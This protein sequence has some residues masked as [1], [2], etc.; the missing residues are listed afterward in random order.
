MC[1]CVCVRACVGVRACLCVWVCGCGGG[2]IA[3]ILNFSIV[4]QQTKS[5]MPLL[6]VGQYS[7]FALAKLFLLF[8]FAGLIWRQQ[9]RSRRGGRLGSSLVV[10][11]VK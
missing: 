10:G 2:I 6:V 5:L 4:Q 11:G 7:F 1:V 9:R 8:R 3:W